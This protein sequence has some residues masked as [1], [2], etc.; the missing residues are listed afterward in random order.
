MPTVLVGL[1]ERDMMS[2]HG[3][4]LPDE[5]RDAARRAGAGPRGVLDDGALNDTDEGAIRVM[6]VA[7]ARARRVLLN[8]G[9]P[10]SWI[11]YTYEQA[12]GLAGALRGAASELLEGRQ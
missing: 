10:V 2:H 9:A 12:L 3:K 6:V 8:F 7:D 5:M 11:G 1:Q 4:R